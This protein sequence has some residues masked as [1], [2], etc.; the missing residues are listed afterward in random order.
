MAVTWVV[1][2]VVAN[3]RRVIEG[4]SRDD[5]LDGL[6]A[7]TIDCVA[8]GASI[9]FM[10]PL[11]HERARAFWT[12]VVDGVA[13]GHRALLVAED[14]AGVVGTVQL[15]CDMPDNQPHRAELAKMQ[16]HH[17]VRRQ[18]LGEALLREADVWAREL[19][20]TLLVLDTVPGSDASRL[21]ERL[22]WIRVGD[23]PRYALWPKGGH[24]GTTFFYRDLTEMEIEPGHSALS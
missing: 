8:G 22:G 10:H 4:P 24:C 18:G 2:R 16:V 5:L 13:Q 21:Y 9:G 7:L 17:R 1:R 15:V 19:E 3:D 11:S 12:R 23:I 14:P 20:K 6:A